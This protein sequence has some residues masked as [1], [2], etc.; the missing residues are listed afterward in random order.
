M[1]RKNHT[2]LNEFVFQG[3]SSFQEYK[4]TLFMIFLTLY[5]LTLTGNAIIMIMIGIDRH[6]HTPMYFFLSM[7]S[8]SET[9]YTLV[10]VPRM[11]ASLVGSSQSISLAGCAT[12]IFFFITLAINNCFLLT[13]MGYDH[14]VAICN[15]L[16]YSVFM[17]KRVCA[18]L[19]WGSCNIGLLVVI[20]QIASVFRAPFCDREVAHYFCDIRLV[21]KLSCADTTL[22]DIVNFII[23]SLVIVVPMGLV[24]ISYILVISTILKIASAE[25][26]KK[27]FATCASHLTVVI[28]HYGCASIAYLKPKSENSV[29]KPLLCSS[30]IALIRTTPL[31]SQKKQSYK[32]L[33]L[34]EQYMVLKL[35]W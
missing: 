18:Q 22:H 25:G 30:Y 33:I 29:E 3:F 20:I 1:M 6:L 14:Y 19:V 31:F 35:M 34:T 27:A 28:I 23:I 4:F 11:L 16:R 32:K 9:V 13:A 10:I 7:L 17:N 26:R 24:F 15:P 5:L 21:M 2:V 8:T 12:Q